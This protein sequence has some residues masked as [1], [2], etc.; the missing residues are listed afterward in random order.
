MSEKA[1]VGNPQT[2]PHHVQVRNDCARRPEYANARSDA[3]SSKVWS[4]RER[5][6]WMGND[7]GHRLAGGARLKPE[8]RAHELKG[9][10]RELAE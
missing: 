5:D 7:G 2:E 4:E 8:G 10:I 6:E 1:F 3:E 9:S